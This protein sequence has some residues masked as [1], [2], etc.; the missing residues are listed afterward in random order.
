ME[1]TAD[2]PT[3]VLI[4]D[5][6]DAIRAVMGRMI[7]RMGFRTLMASGGAAGIQ[8]L[9]AHR[10]EILCVLLDLTMPGMSGEAV[11][12]HLRQVRPDVRVVLMSGHSMEDMAQRYAHLQPTAFLQKPFNLTTLRGTLDAIVASL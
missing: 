10:D 2:N 6:E 12:A 4:I 3:L 8:L 5:D 7:E 1:H 11:L 9:T